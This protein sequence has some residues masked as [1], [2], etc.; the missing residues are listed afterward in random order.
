MI[1]INNINLSNNNMKP[2]GYLFDYSIEHF[3]I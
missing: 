1:Y 2:D 3:D